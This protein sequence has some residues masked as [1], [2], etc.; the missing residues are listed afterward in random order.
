MFPASSGT[1]DRECIQRTSFNHTAKDIPTI[2]PRLEHGVQQAQSNIRFTP[3]PP[4]PSY[5]PLQLGGSIQLLHV[6][7]VVLLFCGTAFALQTPEQELLKAPAAFFFVRSRTRYGL[8]L[9]R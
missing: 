6:C 3:F 2:F 9:A 8:E 4:C 5:P 7:P 1:S